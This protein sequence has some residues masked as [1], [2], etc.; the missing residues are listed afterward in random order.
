MNLQQIVDIPFWFLY[1]TSHLAVM[2][3]IIAALAGAGCII[4]AI[5]FVLMLIEPPYSASPEQKVALPKQLRKTSI[6]LFILTMLIGTVA[7]LAPSESEF[8]AYMAI[9]VAHE[10][11]ASQVGET[12]KEVLLKW[13]DTKMQDM[14]KESHNHE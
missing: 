14:V 12:S 3:G 11:S 2:F 4:C 8:K 10:L 1:L 6:L 13:L 9:V 7:A 5:L